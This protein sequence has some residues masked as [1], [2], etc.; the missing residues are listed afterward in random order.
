MSSCFQINFILNFILRTFGIFFSSLGVQNACCEFLEQQLDPSNC[1]GIRSFAETHGCEELRQAAEKY[2]LKHFV[3]LVDSEEFLQ[4]TSEDVESL[5]KCDNLTVSGITYL[6]LVLNCLIAE[7]IFYQ[8]W[9][10]NFV[11]GGDTL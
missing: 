4:L 7:Y 1:L 2:I 10:Q 6:I 9:F 5:I 3:D 8:K 11:C